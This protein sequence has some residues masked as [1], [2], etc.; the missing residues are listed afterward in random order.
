M[1][2]SSERRPNGKKKKGDNIELVLDGLS[3]HS[4]GI[5]HLALRPATQPVVPHW[6]QIKIPIFSHLL[7][8]NKI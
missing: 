1:N 7:C 6:N 3:D 8:Y 2:L 4:R 5:G